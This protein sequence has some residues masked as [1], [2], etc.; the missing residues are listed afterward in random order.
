MLYF[1]RNKLCLRY[2]R[3]N[4]RR[5]R[6]YKLKTRG[7]GKESGKIIFLTIM[8]LKVRTDTH[9]SFSELPH[10]SPTVHAWGPRCGEMRRK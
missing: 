10:A 7:W 9:K 5:T 8:S 1:F 6:L 4:R 2:S 3:G